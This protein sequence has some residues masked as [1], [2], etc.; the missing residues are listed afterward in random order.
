MRPERRPIRR[1]ATEAPANFSGPLMPRP[2]ETMIEA[3]LS[4]ILLPEAACVSVT[5]ALISPAETCR[6]S[7]GQLTLL[8]LSSIANTFGLKVT[9]A[10]GELNS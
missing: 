9:N 5:F 8:L 2:P 3:S 10:S 4:S 7:I 6:S 1:K